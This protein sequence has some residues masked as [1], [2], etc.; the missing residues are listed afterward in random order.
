MLTRIGIR[1]FIKERQREIRQTH[2]GDDN[3][4]TEAET[5][6]IWPQAQECCPPHDGKN[7]KLIL[8]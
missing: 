5:S 2:R 3:V 1:I 4:K 7:K 6:V 8:L